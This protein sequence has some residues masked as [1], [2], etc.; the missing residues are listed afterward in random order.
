MG[1]GKTITCV[2]LIAATLDS[3]LNFASSPLPAPPPPPHR[4]SDPTLN[5]SHF[6]GSVWG[7]PD[8]TSGSST[9]SAKAQAKAAREADRQE[10]DYI[11]HARLKVKSR[12]T[13]IVCPLSTI[14]NW[15]DQIREHWRGEVSVVGGGS[16]SAVPP[17]PPKAA[18]PSVSGLCTMGPLTQS[19]LATESK[20]EPDTPALT[21]VP[22]APP[23]AAAATRLREGRPCRVYVYHGNARRPDPAFLADFD[24]V[25]TTFS[26]L[27]TEFSKQSRAMPDECED[28]PSPGAAMLEI[29]EQGNAVARPAPGKKGVKRKKCGPGAPEVSSA[30]QS[31][32]WFRVVLDEAQ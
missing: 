16:V 20:I 1:L 18:A 4:E 12:A 28:A 24:V 8:S 32:M 30:L 3:A 29:D 9:Q 27:A 31:V 5:A 15:E 22:V 25:I 7:M 14:S 23:P 21:A 10:A 6:S 13:L 17:V 26:T 19:L 11:R 2:S